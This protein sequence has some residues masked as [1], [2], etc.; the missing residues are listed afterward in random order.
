MEKVKFI[1]GIITGIALVL[2]LQ[3]DKLSILLQALM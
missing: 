3:R 2:F 1:A